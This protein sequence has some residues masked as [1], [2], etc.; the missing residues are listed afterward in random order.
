MRTVFYFMQLS[1]PN[2]KSHDSLEIMNPHM[3]HTSADLQV[4]E[5]THSEACFLLL[6]IHS[7]CP[8]PLENNSCLIW[9]S[10]DTLLTGI[11]ISGNEFTH[12][13]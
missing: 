7:S 9:R 4:L 11:D 6:S 1:I 3:G 5:V 12:L 13:Q 2:K 10:T 8:T